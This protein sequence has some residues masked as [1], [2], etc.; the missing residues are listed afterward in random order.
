MQD[1]RRS[2]LAMTMAGFVLA[3]LLLLSANTIVARLFGSAGFDLTDQGLY[4]LSGGT[5]SIL[6]RINEPITLKFYYSSRL[7]EVV[8]SYGIYADRVRALLQRY[9]SIADGKIKLQILDP[10]PFSDVEDQAT[11]AG[12]QSVPLE[13][14]G[15]AVYFG[16]S[17]SNSTD[18]TET[19][20]FFQRDREKF[21]E[22]DLTRLVQAL[23]FPKK[24]VVGL[25]SS[26]ALDADPMAQM[27]GQQSQP[28]AVLDQLRQ[29]YEVRDLS[30][31]VDAIPDDV[32]VLM[33]VQ[34]QKLSDKTAYAIDQFVL[35][36][37]H[38]LVFADPYSEFSQA[39][40]SPMAP[41]G[42]NAA[43]DFD[44]LLTAWGVKLTPG[45]FVGDRSAAT[46][47]N[48]G[49]EEH[50][51]AAE[52]LAWL[53]LKGDDINT[54]DPITG[55]LQQVNVGTAGA[56]TPIKGAKTSFE[57]LLQSSADSNL[58]DTSRV[59]GAPVPDV[60]GLLKDFS[61]SGQRY[62]IA[63]RVTGLASTAF[64]KGPPKD[65]ADKTPEVKVATQPINV[66]VV[67]DSDL[68]DDRFW[69]EYQNFLG[70]KVAQPIA[71]N[72]DFVQNAVDSLGGTADLINLR[73]RG[74]AV[75]PFTLVDSIRRA[76]DDRY[77]A[78]EKALQAQLAEA[79]QKLAGIKPAEDENGDVALTAEQQKTVDQVRAEIISTRTELRG[80]QLRLRENIDRLKNKLVFF[81]VALV[82]LLVAGF[83]IFIGV[84]R[85][86]RRAERAAQ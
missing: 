19:I 81:D 44:R 78:R 74:T 32:D 69:I 51:M 73:S 47:V 64:P 3:L 70:R 39:H 58:I 62:T 41:Q 1:L 53:S 28:Q 82:P 4:T 66:I 21:L 48:A 40:R 26:L 24:K 46:E 35:R 60:L 36:G 54:S 52:Y 79:Q 6:H 31:T 33:I 77:R 61:P 71:N 55:R 85:V 25:I 2:P 18:D 76:A 42:G 20:P 17:G 7:G 15:E 27:R 59:A 16:L 84:A 86:R 43:A 12:L 65:A 13:Q 30:T 9:A 22:Y 49:D 63:A 68:L 34:P 83:A 57:P 75:R 10:K 38:A 8:P 67:A 45:K 37:G 56:L 80:V 72:G 14:G 5:R 23:A 29:N 11:A 50:P